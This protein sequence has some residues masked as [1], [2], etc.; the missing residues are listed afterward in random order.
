V[1]KIK[2][3][4]SKSLLPDDD[5][6]ITATLS[7][8]G[9]ILREDP[10]GLSAARLQQSIEYINAYLGEDLSLTTI[11]AHLEMS[12]YYFCRLFKQSMGI[13]PHQYLI[14]Q[15]IEKAK[16]LLQQPEYR[17]IDIAAECGFANPSHFA[18]CFRRSTGVSPHQFRSIIN[19]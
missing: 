5:A 2:K 11:A 1:G 10:N 4:I 17:I 15:R 8:R 14:Q 6:R 16:L 12:Q 19:N 13:S 18:R 3:S 9:Q 7:L